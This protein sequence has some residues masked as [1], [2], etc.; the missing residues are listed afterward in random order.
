M[1]P[2]S[3]KRAWKQDYKTTTPSKTR[4]RVRKEIEKIVKNKEGVTTSF[5]KQSLKHLPN[6]IG[7]FSIDQLFHLRLDEYAC[8][9]VNL[10]FSTQPGSHWVAIKFT[11]RK[12][13]IIDSLG[14]ALYSRELSHFIAT[15]AHVRQIIRT[16]L[17]Q[18]PTSNLCGFY[19][20][21]FLLFLQFTSFSSL[22][23]LFSSNLS[24]ND[25]KLLDFF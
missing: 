5:L 15:H 6:F 13:F 22:C 7:V 8:L 20:L 21:F 14:G 25:N 18:E 4:Y 9:I 1:V 2:Y 23:R 24:V 3:T 19:C 17:L 16:P 10:D 12:C 11:P